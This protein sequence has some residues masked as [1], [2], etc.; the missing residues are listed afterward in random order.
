MNSRIALTLLLVGLM[1]AVVGCSAA[2]EAPQEPAQTPSESPAA[3]MRLAPDLYDLE[4]GTAQA[5]GTLEYR[6][7]EGGFWAV[8]GGTEG[9]GN[10]GEVAAVIA[11]GSDFEAELKRLEGK[12]VLATGKRLDGA[13]IRMAG[14][15]I[16]ITAIEEL[17]DAPGIAE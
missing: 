7:L 4:D 10:V 13:S 3:G 6:D 11:N 15:E 2:P 8:I 16:E 1:L 5:V 17:S 14:P 12:T 9:E